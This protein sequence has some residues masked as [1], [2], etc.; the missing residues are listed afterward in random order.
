MSKT[1]KTKKLSWIIEMFIRIQVT[2][3][4]SLGGNMFFFWTRYIFCVSWRRNNYRFTYDF[5]PFYQTFGKWKWPKFRSFALPENFQNW[6]CCAD[7]TPGLKSITIN[8]RKLNN[9]H[10]Q[11]TQEFTWFGKLPTSTETTEKFHYKK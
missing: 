7:S 6:L 1:T 10:T 4:V 8:K 11:R 3:P 5:L 9:K 2:S